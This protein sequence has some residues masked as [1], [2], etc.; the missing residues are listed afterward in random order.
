MRSFKGALGATLR[1]LSLA[2]TY[3][4][5][6]HLSFTTMQNTAA[7]LRCCVTLLRNAVPWATKK[8]KYTVWT[9]TVYVVYS[10]LQ[11]RRYDWQTC[12]SDTVTDSTYWYNPIVDYVVRRYCT[13]CHTY[14]T[15]YYSASSQGLLRV[16]LLVVP[17]PAYVNTIQS[18]S[19][20]LARYLFG[21]L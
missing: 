13:L 10:T 2:D 15:V 18:Y 21:V 12:C 5:V 6:W 3:T 16:I 8:R 1:W 11:Y 17:A 14:C 4:Y 7:W 20:G 9:H 19:T